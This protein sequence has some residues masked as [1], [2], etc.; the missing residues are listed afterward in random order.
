MKAT[1]T[2]KRRNAASTIDKVNASGTFNEISL[3]TVHKHVPP[4]SM[5]A[6]TLHCGVLLGSTIYAGI[7]R[8]YTCQHAMRQGSIAAAAAAAVAAALRERGKAI[9]NA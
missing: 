9:A 7:D 8:T 1:S 2:F 3:H 5:T 6:F 4:Y